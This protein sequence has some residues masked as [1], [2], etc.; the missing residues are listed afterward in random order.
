MTRPVT[1]PANTTWVRKLAKGLGV[2]ILIVVLFTVIWNGLVTGHWKK[3]SAKVEVDSKEKPASSDT[4]SDGKTPAPNASSAKSDGSEKVITNNGLIQVN[5][6][7]VKTPVA[8]PLPGKKIHAVKGKWTRPEDVSAGPY[9]G[10]RK[11]ADKVLV[12]GNENDKRLYIVVTETDADGTQVNQHY[13]S[14]DKGEM[15]QKI[16]GI[17]EEVYSMEFQ[18]LEHDTTLELVISDSPVK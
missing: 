7:E 9:W 12:R 1:P 2:V 16:P 14:N 4:G 5:R 18:A 15:V 10:L 6:F 13:L 11:V 17:P 3:A 8:A